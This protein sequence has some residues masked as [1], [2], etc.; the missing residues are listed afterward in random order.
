MITAAQLAVR[1]GVQLELMHSMQASSEAH[2]AW[3]MQRIREQADSARALGADVRVHLRRGSPDEAL[4]A[5]ASELRAQ[6]IVIG[7]LGERRGT[8]FRLGSHAERLVQQSHVPVLV[9][10]SAEPFKAW[11]RDG[12]P[13]RLVLG[14]DLSRTTAAAM[15]RID[16]WQSLAPC[17]LTAVHLYWPP[18]QFA[19]LGLE[20]PRSYLEPD[21]EVTETLTRELQ[22]HLPA[23]QRLKSFGV[24]VE[25]HLG[26]VGDRLAEI[27]FKREA[28]V[29]VVGCH[30]RNAFASAWEGS[31]ARWA[32][33]C[34]KTSVLCVPTPSAPPQT[35]VPQLRNVLV[36]TDF[37]AAGNAAVGLAFAVCGAGGTVHLAHVVPGPTHEPLS[38][39]DIFAP[40][41]AQSADP[42]T[43]E[44][45]AALAKLIPADARDRLT[46]CHVLEADEPAA[47]ITQAAARLSADAIC[48]GRRGRSGVAGALLGSVSRE[49][50]A[51]AECAV[52]LTQAPRE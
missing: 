3:V 34:A 19:R 35:C 10:R 7:P 38:T 31:V 21:P 43:V 15:S 40:E 16:E 47:A 20:G 52:L 51:R 4:I 22:Q 46:I 44:A 28:D 13:L 42:R 41:R 49:V 36:A 45:R 23:A 25:P 30:T 8:S 1:M 9:V 37:S 6:L 18:Q 27:A 17:D 39:H 12:R 24:Q 11:L 26:R 2:M 14:A 5:L 32:L 48:M 50:L 33:H 29:L